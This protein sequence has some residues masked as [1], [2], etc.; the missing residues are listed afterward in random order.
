MSPAKTVAPPS[1]AARAALDRLW[2]ELGAK[3]REARRARGWTIERLAATAGSSRWSVYLLERGE[4]T[5]VELVVRVFTALGLRLEVDATDP[6]KR[7]RAISGRTEDPVHA[8]MG[9]VEASRLRA[10][11]L[12]VGI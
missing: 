5:S 7:D 6:R 10:I 2:A 11:G 8:A 3:V 1:E 9:E 12:E 4:P